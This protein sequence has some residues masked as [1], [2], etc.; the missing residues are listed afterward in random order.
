MPQVM[1]T[2]RS[3]VMTTMPT[4]MFVQVL[5]QVHPP[6]DIATMT[7]RQLPIDPR[8]PADVRP[9]QSIVVTCFVPTVNIS[10]SV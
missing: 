1:P 4:T 7:M 10:V 9:R 6:R 3:V 8:L 2:D 5:M